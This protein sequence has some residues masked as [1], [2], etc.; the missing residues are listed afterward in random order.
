MPVLVT[1]MLALAIPTATPSPYWLDVLAYATALAIYAVSVAIVS[2][3]LGYITFGHAAFL[4]L[5][6]YTAVILSQDYDWNYWLAAAFSII[7]GL[8]LGA[9]I[10][11]LAARLSGAYFAIA[12]LVIASLL[13]FAAGNLTDLTNGPSGKMMLTSPGQ[14]GQVIG[15]TE[16]QT[17]LGSL[18]ALL[19]FVLFLVHRLIRSPVG[20]QWHGVRENAALAESLG[21]PTL[22]VKVAAITV[23]GGIATLAGALLVPKLV[24]VTPG[25]F[26][27]KNS[28]LGILAVIFG[29]KA[30]LAGPALGGALFAILPEAFRSFGDYNFAA[31][32]L[33][34]LLVVLAFPGGLMSIFARLPR[35]PRLRS[36]PELD[37]ADAPPVLVRV[38]S[39]A[40]GAPVIVAEGIGRRF[41]GL[42]AVTGVDVEVH[43][44]EIVGLIGPNGAGKTTLFTMLSGF[45][46]PSTGRISV[47]GRA[48]ARLTPH[49]IS[50]LGLVRTF[51]QTALFGGLSIRANMMIA[52]ARLHRGSAL[53]AVLQTGSFQ[54]AERQRWLLAQACLREVSILADLDSTAH[55]LPYGQ[56]K[57]LGVA[58]AL[59]TRPSIMLLDEPAAGLNMVEAEQLRVVL[60]TLCKKGLTIVIVDHN[61]TM[62]MSFV[63]RMAVLH[64]GVKIA[65][66]RPQDVAAQPD[67]VEAYLGPEKPI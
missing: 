18:I 59:A 12:T 49:E 25:V 57:L 39:I 16:G 7:P 1:V 13:E 20:R 29:G 53:S 33:I 4:G 35:R 65:D 40:K 38:P 3:Q 43:L 21:I 54:R 50:D 37:G 8:V 44:G 42:T 30:T 36:R 11:I 6:A 51:Q 56:Q 62:L 28:A 45:Q 46:A 17:Y 26:G 63:D 10:G 52:T 64:H 58:M 22:W 23:S 34:L 60:Q 67:V 61:L 32:A 5:G 19:G 24:V 9:L 2:G 47:L 55:S 27:V 48:I 31:F 41:G 66:G 14:F 15:W